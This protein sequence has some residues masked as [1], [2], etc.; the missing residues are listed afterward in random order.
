MLG[1]IF[2]QIDKILSTKLSLTVSANPLTSSVNDYE[3]VEG[4]AER[5]FLDSSPCFGVSCDLISTKFISSMG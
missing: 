1:R 3:E 5:F 4:A 2:S